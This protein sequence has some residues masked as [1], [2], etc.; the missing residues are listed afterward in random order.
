MLG[1]KEVEWGSRS[2]P[3][4]G[5]QAATPGR[6]TGSCRRRA[7]RE[8]HQA[9]G[10]SLT[11]VWACRTATYHLD[12]GTPC[13]SN[14]IS[15]QTWG[16]AHH[17]VVIC[18]GHVWVFQ[19]NGPVPI[20]RSKSERIFPQKKR[21]ENRAHT[22]SEVIEQLSDRFW[23]EHSADYHKSSWTCEKVTYYR[24]EECIFT[25]P[26]PGNMLAFL[27]QVYEF[28]VLPFGLSLP[29]PNA[30]A[31]HAMVCSTMGRH[32]VRFLNRGIC[33]WNLCGS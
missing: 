8:G 14:R 25:H 9:Q 16:H 6:Q 32:S 11:P 4:H 30:F 21:K 17:G 24:P 12:H 19:W 33:I 13:A 3:G 2:V 26:A 31:S 29:L 7:L 20:L 23:V 1:T 5:S 27:G 15:T 18:I 28:K 10:Q 22:G